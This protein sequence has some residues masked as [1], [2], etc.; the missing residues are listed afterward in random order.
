MKLSYIVGYLL[1]NI[2]GNPLPKSN[3]VINLA[4]KQ[5]RALAAN[6]MLTRA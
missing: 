5:I 2:I 4:G 6:L 3:A 1:Y